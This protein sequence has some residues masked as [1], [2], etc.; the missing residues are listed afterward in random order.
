MEGAE[1]K[2]APRKF[3]AM[4]HSTRFSKESEREIE[5]VQRPEGRAPC[6][7]T[8]R[9]GEGGC[10]IGGQQMLCRV[11]ERE[12]LDHINFFLDFHRGEKVEFR[13]VA[14]EL[15]VQLVGGVLLLGQH[16]DLAAVVPHR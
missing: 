3:E 15:G 6:Q 1:R 12:P 8:G 9:G 16:N 13:V 2:M 10:T 14:L 5:R 7:G 11:P 4:P